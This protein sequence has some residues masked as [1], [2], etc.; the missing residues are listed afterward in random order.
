[1]ARLNRQPLVDLALQAKVQRPGSF[2]MIFAA[3]R[4]QASKIVKWC[5]EVQCISMFYLFITKF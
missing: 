3:I 5:N 4:V 2:E 1:M